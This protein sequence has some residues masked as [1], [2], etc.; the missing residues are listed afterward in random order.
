MHHLPDG[1][2]W[3]LGVCTRCGCVWFKVVSRYLRGSL[4]VSLLTTM[5]TLE[6]CQWRGW[7]V[8]RHGNHT[9]YIIEFQVPT[10]V[11]CCGQLHACVHEWLSTLLYISLVLP[12]S[13]CIQPFHNYPCTLQCLHRCC[14]QTLCTNHLLWSFH[15]G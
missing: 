9:W 6:Y 2:P 13:L 5:P 1:C 14:N 15:P 7:T 4:R 8:A 10:A 11:Q 3:Q 12:A